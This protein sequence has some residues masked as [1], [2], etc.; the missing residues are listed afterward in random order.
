MRL[1]LLVQTAKMRNW[2]FWRARV[3]FYDLHFQNFSTGTISNTT[4]IDKVLLARWEYYYSKAHK[5]GG[6]VT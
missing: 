6:G 2:A 5:I 4:Y 3:Y 1:C